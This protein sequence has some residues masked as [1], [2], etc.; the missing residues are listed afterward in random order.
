M[1]VCILEGRLQCDVAHS[2]GFQRSYQVES[3]ERVEVSSLTSA[4]PTKCPHGKNAPRLLPH[5]LH[6]SHHKIDPRHKW[7]TKTYETS[8]RKQEKLCKLGWRMAS[9]QKKHEMLKEKLVVWT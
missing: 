6:K 9:P 3:V 8:R 7:K 5:T 1:S 4:E 2:A